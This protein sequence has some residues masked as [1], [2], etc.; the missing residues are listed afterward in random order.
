MNRQVKKVGSCGVE[1]DG[2]TGWIKSNAIWKSLS[3]KTNDFELEFRLE[4]VFHARRVVKSE[5]WHVHRFHMRVRERE[6]RSDVE[7]HQLPETGGEE[8]NWREKLSEGKQSWFMKMK[9]FR[10]SSTTTFLFHTRDFPYFT[11][12]S[13][14]TSYYFC[15]SSISDAPSSSWLMRRESLWTRNFQV[16]EE[17]ENVYGSIS[18]RR[19]ASFTWANSHRTC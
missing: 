7:A 19:L 4:S 9:F 5:L 18:V 10:I 1:M 11:I 17:S 6:R 3:V 12:F 14:R 16:N 2:K 13:S 8:E 15:F